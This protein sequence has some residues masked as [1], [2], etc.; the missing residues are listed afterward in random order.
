MSKTS[1]KMSNGVK[2]QNQKPKTD[3][4][5]AGDNFSLRSFFVVF[6][7]LLLASGF[8]VF[9][10]VFAASPGDIVINEF[11]SN[12]DEWVEL[13]NTSDNDMDLSGFKLS[14]L[15]NPQGSFEG[16]PEEIPTEILLLELT[17]TIPA[18]GILVFD[19]S[20]SKLNN[21]GDSIALYNG[22]IDLSNL[23]Q[24]VTYGTVNENYPVTA[25]LGVAP[26]SGFSDAFLDGAWQTAQTPSKGW[27]NDAGREDTA[28][29][30]GENPLSIDSLLADAGIDSN[31]GELDN[32]SATPATEDEG[33][34]YFE[35]EGEGKIVF[36]T[37]L[38]LTNQDTVAVLQ[39]L[40]T[41]MEM[42]DGHIEF[43]SATA[44][45]MTD[46]GARIYMYSLGFSLTPNIIVKDDDGNVI[47][48]ADIVS[49]IDYDADEGTLTFD[50]SHF[51]QFYA[52][53]DTNVYVS[54]DEGNDDNDGTS[55]NPFET[56]QQGIESVPAGG[57]VHVASGNY[58]ENLD[59]E[60]SLTLLG[61]PGDEEEAGPGE[62]APVIS[63]DDACDR[64][65]SIEAND[66][67]VKGFILEGDEC[68]E[69]V[70]K[71]YQD[72]TG[73]V[74]PNNEIKSNID[75]AIGVELGANSSDNLITDNL[76]HDNRDGVWISGSQDN[77]ISNNEIYEN[78]FGIE[79]VEFCDEDEEGDECANDVSGNKITGN[80]IHDNNSSGIYINGDGVTFTD[81]T[82][83][84]NQINENR[85]YYGIYFD[86]TIRDSAV[87]VDKNTIDGNSEYG[88]YFASGIS[89]STV[90]IGG[91]SE[92]DGNTI[93]DNG[94]A[95]VYLSGDSGS[96]SDSAVSL[97]NNT[98]S[99]NA[100]EG[101]YVNQVDNESTLDVIGNAITENGDGD[102]YAGIYI[103]NV[104][105]D[106]TVTFRDNDISL[107][108][109]QGVYVCSEG[110]C[111]S[112]TLI[113]QDNTIT[114][115]DGSGLEAY[116]LFASTLDVLENTISGNGS[117]DEGA[118][119]LIVYIGDGEGIP[120]TPSIVTVS[121][122]IFDGNF[123]G[124][125]IDETD[126]EAEVTIGED[127]IIKRN[128]NAGIYLGSSVSGVAITGNTIEDNGA[129]SE[130]TGV[131]INSAA[132]NYARNNKIILNAGNGVENND[133]ENFDA[134]QNWWG[135][136]DGTGP[137]HET[138][139]PDGSGDGVSDNVDFDPWYIN[140]GRTILS[141][142]AVISD[143]VTLISTG[144]DNIILSSDVSGQADL[145]NN[146]TNLVL[147]DDSNLDLSAGLTDDAVT[148]QSGDAEVPIVL[149]NSDLEDV[150]VS[151]PDGTLITGPDGWDGIIQPPTAG[152]PDGNAPA[153]FSVG[154]TVISI[155]SPD[156][157]LVFD[158]PV[159][160]L[161]A[162]VTGA[163]GYRPAGSDIWVEITNVC[164]GTYANPEDPISPGECAI[165]N[166]TDTKIITFHFTSFGSLVATS[167]PT[168]APIGGGGGSSGGGTGG[169]GTNNFAGGIHSEPSSGGGSEGGEVLGA[170]VGPTI[171]D[172][173][174]QI[175]SLKAQ[176]E[177]LKKKTIPLI[178]L[179]IQELFEELEK[180]QAMFAL[181]LAEQGE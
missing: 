37:T 127:N 41:A 156:G 63:V 60:K 28:P 29:L 101:V 22:A 128:N 49:N 69:S 50:A 53:E 83:S 130:T 82:I 84:D 154:D 91:D 139:N 125:Y 124:I 35:K 48:G 126:G 52:E 175:A 107:N 170:S 141:S 153:G 142:V 100:H 149:T 70:V 67:T 23:W 21:G 168:P 159:T 99:D 75:G 54:A 98:I 24:R 93:T 9:R 87:L 113:L 163:V 131:V 133:G 15:T 20:G 158:N 25:G 115:N 56:I 94:S 51:T 66:V 155:G 79:L 7:A 6:V 172:L 135:E 61:D 57:T 36:E 39:I 68:G 106:S 132:G 114:A 138:L 58:E 76:I 143:S 179:L 119:F 32:P 165:S 88:I 144:S 90:T 11:V 72:I 30:L 109:G 19:I 77:T 31:I 86:G 1:H 173:E 121:E 80:N 110:E 176:I 47:D 123:Y 181:L 104:L 105:G 136:L 147:S 180:L 148:L 122:N 102:Y 71:I 150:T 44:Q 137:L 146:I 112:S 43:D 116:Q 78:G 4:S 161:L 12:G 118:G 145:P 40:G 129:E 26:S 85:N 92:S 81:L 34:L 5:L 169:G 55:E 178:E 16:P 157:T 2:H 140:A 174:S 89:D 8:F 152:T 96:I 13:L 74:I 97:K 10:Q 65:I 17:G 27:F 14:E 151:I 73:A 64:V 18:H 33:A 103:S 160:I 120:S 59:I 167:V 134:K 46:T 3:L 164:G 38:N 108:S 117:V 177:E 111:S 42:S 171:D 166:G 45:A 95:G 62:G 162:G